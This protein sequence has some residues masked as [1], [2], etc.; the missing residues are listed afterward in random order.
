MTAVPFSLRRVWLIACVTALEAA[1]Q[2]VFHLVLVLAMGLVLGAHAFREFNFGASELKFMADFGFGALTVFGSVLT[3]VATAQ[4]F[5]GELEHRTALTL[6]AKPVWRA[7]FILG[8]I[9]GVMAVV[10]G[11]CALV[12]L[13]LLGTLYFRQQTLLAEHPEL[14]ESARALDPMAIIAVGVANWLK[15][16]VLAALTLLIASFARTSLYAVIV[17][18]VML[19]ICH[20]HPL[21]RLA[22]ARTDSWLLR[23]VAGMVSLIF[24]DFQLFDL[25]A[26]IDSVGAAGAASLIRLVAYA[27]LYFS[28]LGSLAVYSF[29]RREL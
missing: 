22:S 7:E 25:S 5:F 18:F 4:L 11:F 15:F 10:T 2:R 8:K 29:N 14:S 26:S 20:L 3:I 24:P 13:L 19:L 6:L 23:G 16:G 28:V 17:G 27:G 21:A 1:R 12:T 9:G